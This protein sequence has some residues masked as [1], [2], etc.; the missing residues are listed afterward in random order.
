MRRNVYLVLAIIGVLVPYV[1]FFR[2]LSANG[3][4]VT[5]LIQHLFANDISTFFAVDLILSII[6]FWIYM[7]SEAT[8]LRMKN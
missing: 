3:L 7:V 5:L 6:V 1:F 2:F 4:N 8:K